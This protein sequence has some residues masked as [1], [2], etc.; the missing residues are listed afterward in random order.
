MF[1]FVRSLK[2]ASQ[3]WS[4]V[5]QAGIFIGQSRSSGNLFFRQGQVCKIGFIFSGKVLVNLVWA[6]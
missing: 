4:K 2:L 5:W 3:F 6:F 1:G